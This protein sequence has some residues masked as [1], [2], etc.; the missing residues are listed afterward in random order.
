[1]YLACCAVLNRFHRTGVSCSSLC[2]HNWP[3]PHKLP[4][5]AKQNVGGLRRAWY[6]HLRQHRHSDRVTLTMDLTV[7]Q[8]SELQKNR[9]PSSFGIRRAFV[10]VVKKQGHD[11][12]EWL[13]K[14]GWL[15]SWLSSFLQIWFRICLPTW[16]WRWLWLQLRNGFAGWIWNPSSA[17]D[18]PLHSHRPERMRS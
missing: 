15:W 7:C 17:P 2:A 10:H 8:L 14:A 9:T 1:M 6:R 12:D 16:F 4:V 18:K 13:N 3:V 11:A 5:N